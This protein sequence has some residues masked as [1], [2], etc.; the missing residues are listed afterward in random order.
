[1][2]EDLNWNISKNTSF[3]EASALKYTANKRKE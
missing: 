3:V 1:M 2:D